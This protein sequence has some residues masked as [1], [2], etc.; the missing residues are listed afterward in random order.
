M[1]KGINLGHVPARFFLTL[2]IDVAK[3]SEGIPPVDVHGARS[4]DPFSTGST[5]GE[6]GILLGFNFDERIENHWAA[7][8]EVH[9]IRGEVLRSTRD[10]LRCTHE[11]ACKGV[12]ANKHHSLTGFW[13]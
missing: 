9:W 8:V 11:N 12:W 10:P 5:E 4:A 6:R 7:V 1:G 3:A 2:R 13:R